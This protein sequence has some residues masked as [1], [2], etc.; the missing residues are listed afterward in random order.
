MDEG[1]AQSPGALRQITFDEIPDWQTFQD[2]VAD[3]FRYLKNDSIKEVQVEQVG[4]GPDGG[5]DIFVNFRLTDSVHCY[6]RKWIVQCKFYNEIVL[7]SH[8]KD[9]NPSSL[10]AEHGAD[11]YLL[12]CKNDVQSGLAAALK[13]H[14]TNSPNNRC[15]AYWS[16]NQFITQLHQIPL[17]PVIQRYFPRYYEYAHGREQK[18]KDI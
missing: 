16:G 10:V 17:R 15:Y 1:F 12:V 3:Y 9:V 13:Q 6:N 4:I 8:L 11:G 14:Q 18:V 7:K 2:L 5:V